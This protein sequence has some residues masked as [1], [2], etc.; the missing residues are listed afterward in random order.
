M[1]SVSSG[2]RADIVLRAKGSREGGLGHFTRCSIL[3]RELATR[4]LGTLFLVDGD[5]DGIAFLRERGENVLLLPF[6]ESVSEEAGRV[7]EADAVRSANVLIYD[8][9]ECAAQTFEYDRLCRHV[10]VFDLEPG[11]GRYVDLFV[12]GIKSGLSS[13]SYELG[14]S[15]VI[16]GP[17]AIVM[18]PAF[19]EA[20]KKD[21]DS[22]SA[23]ERVL[24]TFGSSD[25]ADFTM[26]ALD[27]LLPLSQE[28][29]WSIDVVLG[30]AYSNRDEVRARLDSG[31]AL[32]RLHDNPGHLAD[33]MLG[34]DMSICSGGAGTLHELACVGLPAICLCQVDH[35]ADNV[36]RFE[37]EGIV[38]GLH[39]SIERDLAALPRMAHALAD[40]P[41]ARAAMSVRGKQV[42]DGRGCKVVADRVED[43]LS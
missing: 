3:S 14:K 34:S 6:G 27:L 32:V 31:D 40:D 23:V 30:R 13:N 28:R 38:R 33:L 22:R 7:R 42:Q 36:R 16:E 41:E 8:V 21:R 11:T 5:E 20:H 24:L 26:S 9:W 25:P 10:V 12:N 1:T 15:T 18:H 43:M 4:G 29:G 37:A 35:Q 17:R 2:G 19:A 39:E